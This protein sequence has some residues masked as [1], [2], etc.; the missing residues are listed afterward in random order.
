MVGENFEIHFFEMAK[1]AL[2]KSRFPAFP[3]TRLEKDIIFQPI[4]P[5]WQ[6]CL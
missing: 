4:Q 5:M 3:A 2:K 6:P 1:N